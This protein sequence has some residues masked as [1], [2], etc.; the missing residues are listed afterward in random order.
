MNNINRVKDLTQVF[1]ERWKANNNNGI[2]DIKNNERD[3]NNRMFGNNSINKE[4][5]NKPIDRVNRLN[6]KI[7]YQNNIN[8]IARNIDFNNKFGR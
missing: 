6:E 1:N 8:R 2:K 3:F 4:I 5:S 7:N